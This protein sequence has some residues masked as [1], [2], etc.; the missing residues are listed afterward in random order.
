MTQVKEPYKGKT[1]FQVVIGSTGFIIVFVAMI[2]L[3]PTLSYAWLIISVIAGFFHFIA[4][5]LNKIEAVKDN[6]WIKFAP[7]LIFIVYLLMLSMRA[8]SYL[9]DNDFVGVIFPLISFVITGFVASSSII[10]KLPSSVR[11]KVLITNDRLNKISLIFV[12]IVGVLGASFGM[13]M[14]RAGRI[15]MIMFVIGAISYI[16]SL[17]ITNQM[18]KQFIKEKRQNGES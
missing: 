18:F 17:M 9:L 15:G 8:F 10:D 14:A 5:I 4:S 3:L 16:V 7:V 11:G 2:T 6:M 13:F 12:S 1:L